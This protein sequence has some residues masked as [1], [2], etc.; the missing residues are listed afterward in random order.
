MEM[1]GRL[2]K[3]AHGGEPLELVDDAVVRMLREGADKRDVCRV[4]GVDR[5]T[6]D[7]DSIQSS[8]ARRR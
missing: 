2:N 3:L 8:C 1:S 4:L 7:A 6:V 5:R